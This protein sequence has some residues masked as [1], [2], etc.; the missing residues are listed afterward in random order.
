MKLPVLMDEVVAVAK[1]YLPRRTEVTD[2][3]RT[4]IVLGLLLVVASIA[5]SA[6]SL[7]V[8]LGLFSGGADPLIT[9]SDVGKAQLEG[10]IVAFET[11]VSMRA[12]FDYTSESA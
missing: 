4:G 3:Y 10:A 2:T 12:D 8:A 9:Y 11:A 5:G 1:K 6:M 7:D